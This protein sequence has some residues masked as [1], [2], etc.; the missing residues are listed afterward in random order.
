MTPQILRIGF[1]FQ[2]F[3]GTEILEGWG[4]VFRSFSVEKETF[5]SRFALLTLS[6]LITVIRFD[7]EILT[8]PCIIFECYL[9]FDVIYSRVE[10][11]SHYLK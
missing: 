6:F 2:K 3:I 10:G 11:Y 1:H 5:F 7:T 4:E 8:T 9:E